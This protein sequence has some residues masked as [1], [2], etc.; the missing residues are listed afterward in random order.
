DS[1]P[2]WSDSLAGVISEVPAGGDVAPAPDPARR[3]ARVNAVHLRGHWREQP[4]PCPLHGLTSSPYTV[5]AAGHVPYPTYV[6]QRRATGAKG[7]CR[8]SWTRP[9]PSCSYGRPG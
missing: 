3:R 5:S 8:P 1:S 4:T 7:S 2:E 9:R 6:T